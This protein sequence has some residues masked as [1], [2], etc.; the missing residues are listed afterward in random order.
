[1]TS[2]PDE[3]GGTTGTPPGA[4]PG[5]GLPAQETADDPGPAGTQPAGYPEQVDPAQGPVVGAAGAR[6]GDLEDPGAR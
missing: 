3:D 5:V 6:T 2:A 4:E 1:M